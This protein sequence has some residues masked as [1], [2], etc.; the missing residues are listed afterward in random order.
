M[1]PIALP[2]AQRGVTLI[3][4]LIMLV[5]ITLMVTS[6]FML[7]NTNL[8]SVGNLQFRNEAIAAANAA[9]DK[10]F[11]LAVLPVPYVDYVDINNDGTNDFSIA[12]T[13][14]CLRSSA[15][16]TAP[17]PGTG[18]SVTLGFTPTSSDHMVIWDYDAT[19]TDNANTGAT[20]RVRQ[21]IRQRLTQ[22]QCDALC[23]PCS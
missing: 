23:S 21:G 8:K 6:S 18:S 13:R 17:T 14:S 5:L 15:V 22:A 11:D 3:V 16:V 10:S 9:I 2:R 12:I 4:G 1:K 19:V 7:S 20:V